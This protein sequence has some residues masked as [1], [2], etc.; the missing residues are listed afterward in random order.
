M[1]AVPKPNAGPEIEVRFRAPDAAA[2]ANLPHMLAGVK[3][4]VDGPTTQTVRDLYLDTPDWWL[5]QAGLACRIR[6]TS[7]SRSTLCAPT[8]T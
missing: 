6:T 2:L 1:S 5:W 8:N 3:L 4:E 7:P